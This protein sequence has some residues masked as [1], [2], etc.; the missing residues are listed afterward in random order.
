MV[1]RLKQN[2]KSYLHMQLKNQNV[3]KN[4]KTSKYIGC[5]IQQLKKWI[6]YQ[7][8]DNMN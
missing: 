7:F 6:E 1:Y 2:Q 4:Q 3:V 5:S 8:Q